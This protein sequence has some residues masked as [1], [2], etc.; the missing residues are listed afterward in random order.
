[1]ERT[2][3]EHQSFLSNTEVSREEKSQVARLETYD[4]LLDIPLPEKEIGRRQL[5]NKLNS[6]NFRDQTVK[7]IFEHRD[8]AR[9]LALK[10]YPLPC[11]DA[12][13]VCQWAEAFD[14]DQLIESYRFQCLHV[15]KDQQLL[16]VQPEVNAIDEHQ[17]IL[18]L[19]ETCVEI[20]TRIIHRH[21]CAEVSAYLFQN[22]ATYFGNLMDYGAA[23]FRVNV[24]TAPPQTF[25]WIEADLPVTIVFTKGDRTLYS[26]E[27]RIVRHDRG[28]QSR[29]F[30]LEPTQHQMRRF[31]N[32]EFRSFR[33][34][35]SPPPDV[36]FQHPLFGKKIF[37]KVYDIS[38]SGLSVEEDASSTVL[39]P[40]LI[41]PELDLVFSDGTTLRCMAQVVYCKP[42]NDA[43][44][45]VV[46]CGLTILDMNVEDHIRLLG[47]M[48]QT[49]DAHAY[50]CKKVDMDALWDFFFETGFIYPEKYE[51]IQ[52]NKEKIKATYE[53][54]YNKNPSVASHFI[55]QRDGHILAH[56]AA[57]RFYESSWLLHHHAAVRVANNRGGLIVLNQ[58]GRF[59]NESHR[60]Y[61]MNMDYVFCY[62]RP[63]NKFPAHVFGGAARNIRN[64]K[65]CSLDHFA[66][67]HHC[68]HPDESNTFPNHW[69]LTEVREEDLRDLETFYEEHS[70]GLMLQNLHLSPD[71]FKCSGVTATYH[72]IG[73]KRERHL[74][75]LRYRDKLSAIIMANVAD[76][77]LNM[78]E[79]TNAITII[80]VNKR[81]LTPGIVQSVVEEVSHYYEN[82]EVPVLLYP[83]QTAQQMGIHS[84]K[85]YAM[86]V[87][88]TRNLD[89]YFR[90]L[91]RL[92][93]YIQH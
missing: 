10:A 17:I 63:D 65:I 55:Y 93:K 37:L 68:K 58:I 23:Q 47:W 44:R 52:A 76:L 26:G 61:S 4:A 49:T 8:Y 79:L 14:H 40:G 22:G 80:V 53:K 20:S 24:G 66:Y 78:S 91:K 51:F 86:W 77:G 35:L 57:V 21:Q 43:P 27:C 25:R 59:I 39:L 90:F 30:I 33:H 74:I 12:R 82:S 87:Y 1:M 69:Q 32:R 29:Q 41:L 73:L 42:Q 71:R 15:P 67:F 92:L 7:V 83:Q 81:Q 34:Q 85:Q 31:Q 56:I 72:R 11:K 50:V 19:P 13:L 38:G 89:P 28:I 5:I 9:T 2:V 84:E 75:A 36:S 46:R 88:D 48:H 60:L 62:Y 18:T 54:L 70:G 64:P 3:A 16:K 45:P 6:L